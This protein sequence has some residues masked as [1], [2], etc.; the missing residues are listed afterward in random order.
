MLILL[1]I[2]S[3]VSL[4]VVM[5]ALDSSKSNAIVRWRR[6]FLWATVLWGLVIVVSSEVLGLWKSIDRFNLSLVWVAV[7]IGTNWVAYKLEAWQ[8][9][10]SHFRSLS[11]PRDRLE[12]VLIVLLVVVIGLLLVLAIMSPPNNVDSFIYHMSRVS[13]W[14]QNQSLEHYPAAQDLQLLKPTWAE[15][16]I[17]HLRVLWGSDRPANLVQWFSMVGSLI[18]ISAIAALIGANRRGQ[19]AASAFAASIPM[20]IL[21]STSTQNDY[22][23]AYWS[24]VLAFLVVSGVGKPL[25]RSGSILLAVAVGLGTL[26]KGTFYVYS[27][28]FLAWYFLASRRG[29]GLVRAMERAALVATAVVLLNLGFWGRNVA[30]FGG[31]YGTSDWLQAN[32]FINISFLR[33]SADINNLEAEPSQP[34]EESVDRQQN[35]ESV[36]PD[37]RNLVVRELQM[38]GRNFNTPIGIFQKNIGRLMRLAPSIY[39]SKYADEMAGAA[40][41]HEDT[42]G[43]FIHLLLLPAT[44]VILV[45][46]R[47]VRVTPSV[48]GYTVATLGAFALIPIVIGHGTG[49]WAVRY[50]LPFFVLWGALFGLG[51]GAIRRGTVAVVAGIG[52][53][54]ASVPW[55]LLNNT[56][57]IIGLPPWPTAIGSILTSSGSE[58]LFATNPG[59]RDDYEDLTS[60][61]AESSCRSVGLRIES[62]V[63]EYPFWWLLKAPESGIEIELINAADHTGKYLDPSFQ[64]CAVICSICG[65]RTSFNGMSRVGVSDSMVLFLVSDSEETDN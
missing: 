37:H 8:A 41:N 42:A 60:I 44:I 18:G 5:G 19:L 47:A 65:D 57:P 14:A 32:L 58:V 15:M 52:L 61:V 63:F 55:L 13:H 17:L 39:G 43:N 31:P 29:E 27:I 33:A 16:A 2:G 7:L 51:F 46:T 40:W 23:A 24:V 21:Q 49:T 6:A 20:G 64:P 25:G 38:A 36:L 30:T 56:R 48:L 35:D 34:R 12:R 28:P 53:L 54:I 11:M 22:V 9:A 3:L 45:A 4:F 26:T 10:T 1:P 59:L 50:Q 62:S